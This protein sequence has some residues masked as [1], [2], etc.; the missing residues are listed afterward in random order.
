MLSPAGNELIRVKQAMCDWGSNWELRRQIPR[1]GLERNLLS[2]P[3]IK[4]DLLGITQLG[5]S[6]SV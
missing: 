2:D 6:A 1:L 5:L 4:I 3:H